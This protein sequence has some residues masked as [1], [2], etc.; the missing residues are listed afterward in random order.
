VYLTARAHCAC[1]Y[2]PTRIHTLAC[3][4]HTCAWAKARAHPPTPTHSFAH[5]ITHALQPPPITD[6]LQCKR[7]SRPTSLRSEG[8]QR[9][10][11]C[12]RCFLASSTS[13]ALTRSTRS[14]SS[15]RA[16]EVRTRRRC[17]LPQLL[18][19]LVAF[20]L[21][22]FL[23]VALLL[24]GSLLLPLMLFFCADVVSALNR[25]SSAGYATN[26]PC[27]FRMCACLHDCVSRFTRQ[28]ALE[29]RRSTRVMRAT[30]T[31]TMCRTLSRTLTTQRPRNDERHTRSPFTSCNPRHRCRR[32]LIHHALGGTQ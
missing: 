28:T 3:T 17:L 26:M 5:A 13:S 14:G 30:R 19:S 22:C 29:P 4:A 27:L 9:Q 8:S 2:P 6:A 20:V 12:R 1:P 23:D 18:T 15:L 10:R 21:A 11:S 16:T 24:M 31:T 32:I 7:P 25:F